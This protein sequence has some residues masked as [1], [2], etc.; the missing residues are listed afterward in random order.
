MEVLDAAAVSYQ[1]VLTK[2]D[3]SKPG[4]I[5]AMKSDLG[6]ELTRH[7]A[8]HP[9][10]LVTSAHKHQGIDE[11]RAALAALALGAPE[12]GDS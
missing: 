9:N 1:L 4:P 8:A 11:L 6:R 7:A 5:D 12:E 2:A 3:K 10:I